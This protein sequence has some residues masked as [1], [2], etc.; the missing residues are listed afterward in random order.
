MGGHS[1]ESM[2]SPDPSNLD[3]EL[4][5]RWG[6]LT[7]TER[8]NVSTPAGQVE[9]L[10]VPLQER[11]ETR[12]VFVA[13]VLRDLETAGVSN[14]VRGAIQ[15]GLITLLI[16]S[17]IA[18]RVAEGVLQPVRAVTATADRISS[19]D[20]EQRIPVA[21]GD[22]ISELSQTFNTMLDKIDEA[23]ATQRR[24]VDD[25]GHELRTPITV[26][27]GH[28]ELLD[29]DDPAERAATLAL[30][31]DELDRMHRIVNDLLTLAKSERPD[32]LA[33]GPVDIAVLTDEL[34]AKSEAIGERDWRRASAGR[35][36]VVA[37]RQRLT[38]AMMQLAQNAVQHT[39]DGV[40]IEIGSG[41]EGSMAQLWVRDTGEGIPELEQ[42]RIFDRFSRGRRRSSEGAGLGLSIVQAIAE[43]HHG[44]V[45]LHSQPGDTVFTISLPVDQPLAERR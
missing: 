10:A 39:A 35:G 36:I 6:A 42:G 41:I 25:A 32:F 26:I 14:A 33:L 16:G 9:Y 13:T 5:R 34:L 30:V 40:R 20:I 37:D 31:D 27:R 19:G 24:F 44:T 43:A 38:Q 28:L 8:G 1:G 45:R 29:E 21:G 11:G 15:A 3:D 4:A 12:G 2:P 23:F 7:E 18:W 22:E 17:L